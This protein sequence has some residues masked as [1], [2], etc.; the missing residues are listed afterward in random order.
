MTTLAGRAA[1]LT[2]GALALTL[3][4]AAARGRGVAAAVANPHTKEGADLA[5][6]VLHRKPLHCGPA[7]PVA[8]V[9][10]QQVAERV[11]R[12]HRHERAVPRDR[13]E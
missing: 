4:A 1:A 3:M 11:V 5:T 8:L 6:A 9:P 2:R 13:A 7:L 10:A 12:G